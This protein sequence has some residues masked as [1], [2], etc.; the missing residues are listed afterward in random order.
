MIDKKIIALSS[1]HGTGK[2]TLAYSLCARLKHIGKNVVVLDELARR[3]PFPINRNGE[4]KSQVWMICRQIVYE[5]ELIN[6][7]FQYIIVDRSVLDPYIYGRVL[8]C[9]PDDFS[10]GLITD[11]IRRY[12][13]KIYVPHKDHFDHQHDDGIRDMNP[14]FRNNVYNKLVEVYKELDLD[15]KIVEH[16][17]EVFRDLDVEWVNI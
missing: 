13:H 1:T 15:H 10:L 11:H 14:E 8:G 12:Y 16:S 17:S 6:S 4:H 3:C 7:D 2:S 5:L 9:L